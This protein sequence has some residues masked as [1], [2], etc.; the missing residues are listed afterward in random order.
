MFFHPLRLLFAG[1]SL[2]F[3]AFVAVPALAQTCEVHGEGSGSDFLADIFDLTDQRLIG[4]DQDVRLGLY[5]LGP[6][7]FN[8]QF[9]THV[10]SLREVT[11]LNISLA[12]NGG[13]VEV[14]VIYANFRN[15]D[16]DPELSSLINMLRAQSPGLF[17]A[18][19]ALMADADGYYYHFL[20]SPDQQSIAQAAVFVDK[21]RYGRDQIALLLPKALNDTLL[22]GGGSEALS[23]SLR[24][25]PD[26]VLTY[27]ADCQRLPRVDLNLLDM[28]YAPQ[29]AA[30]LDQIDTGGLNAQP[31]E[32]FR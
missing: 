2:L 29:V 24:N 30:S 6:L 21:R 9:Q 16:Q 15:L 22:V 23:P 5:G 3:G 20:L 12:S 4:W 11:G 18:D 14:A 1:L 28:A 10:R 17:G 8:R 32:I 31:L 27:F 7:A 19:G 26:V 13:T 25:G